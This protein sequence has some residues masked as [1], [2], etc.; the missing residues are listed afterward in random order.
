ML[1]LYRT[2]GAISFWAMALLGARQ[3]GAGLGMWEA[4][5]LPNLLQGL[6][7]LALAAALAYSGRPKEKDDG[8]IRR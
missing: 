2:I 1:M 3:F 5:P 4:A 7:L 6:S 8:S